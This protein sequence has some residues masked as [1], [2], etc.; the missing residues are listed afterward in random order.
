MNISERIQLL[1]PGT[2][3]ELI[4]IDLSPITKTNGPSD[5][6]YFHAGTNELNGP[7]VWQGKTYNAWPVECEGF[8]LTT[9]GTLPRPRLR[10][11]NVTGLLSAA[12]AELDDLVGA[13]VT[14]RRTFAEYLDA[15]NFVDGNP[16]ADPGQHLPD[17]VYDIERKITSNNLFVEYELASAMDLEGYKLPGRSIVA[18]YCPWRYR[19][20]RNGAFDYEGVGDCSYTGV[21]YLTA[22]DEVTTNP[23]LDVCSKTLT[24][25]KV[26]FGANVVLPF[27]GFPAAKAYKL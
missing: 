24:A 17:D 2:I 26:R 14:R 18:N 6:F 4:E 15:V 8:D 5:H 16:S 22:R 3:L 25:C 9:K 13:Q 19:T 7:V 21:I 11:A 23:A 27:G 20:Y 1:S 12:N 10:A